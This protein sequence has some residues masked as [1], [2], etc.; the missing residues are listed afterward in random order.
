MNKEKIEKALDKVRP[1]LQ[2]EGG[3]VEL[4]G[5]EDKTVKVRLSGACAGCP[6][7]QMTL[8]QGIERAIKQEISEVEK[9]V[10]V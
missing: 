3:N 1:M 2:S 8:T 6:M 5:V 4:V 9:V 10:A 7:S